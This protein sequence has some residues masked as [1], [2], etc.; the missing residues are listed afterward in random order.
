MLFKLKILAIGSLAF[1]LLPFATM[2]ADVN[3]SF[4]T[5]VVDKWVN[6]PS[7]E[8]VALIQIMTC[9][10]GRGG[11]NEK[12]FA[13][14]SW[15]GIVDEAKCGIQPDD[16]SG[17]VK[18][19]TVQF[20][21]SYAGSGTQEVV[22]FMEQSD[23]T[24]VVMNLQIKEGVASLPP[25]G[26]FYS[27]FY[28][29]SDEDKDF[30]NQTQLLPHGFGEVVQVGS[31][32]V[33]KSAISPMGDDEPATVSKVVYTNGSVSDLTYGF[34]LYG[35]D[36]ANEN[37][38]YIGKA[39]A[40]EVYSAFID[41]NNALD[42]SKNQCKFRDST[43]QSSWM[44]ALYDVNSGAR[45]KLT[46]PPFQFTV[47]ADGS[48][49]HAKKSNTWMDNNSLRLGMDKIESTFA[50]TRNDTS[51]PV[52]MQWT[53]T[54]METK[55]F[56]PFSPQ[57]DDIF[58]S[59]ESVDGRAKWDGR[60]LR[61]GMGNG[62]YSTPINVKTRVWSSFYNSEF[63]YDGTAIPGTW[64]MINMTPF[65]SSDYPIAGNSAHYKCFATYNCPHQTAASGNMNPTLG[66]YS[67]IIADGESW[68]GEF[69]GGSGLVH[70]GTTQFNYY[71][72]AITPPDGYM[73]ATLYW[74]SDG[75]ESLTSSDLPVKF[76]FNIAS[77][78]D[79]SNGWH[80]KAV[81]HENSSEVFFTANAQAPDNNNYLSSGQM[82]ATLIPSAS[83]CTDQN[84]DTCDDSVQFSTSQYVYDQVLIPKDANGTP[85]DIS[86]AM[87]MKF[88]QSNLTDLNGNGGVSIEYP[89]TFRENEWIEWLSSTCKPGNMGAL[90]LDIDG[91]NTT[92]E[93]LI[94]FADFNDKIVNIEYD[95]EI[96]DFPGYYDRARSSNISLINP[97]DGTLF[98]DMTNGNKYKYKA[99]GI[100]TL[101]V[102]KASAATC[103]AGVQLTDIPN[104]FYSND[105][106]SLGNTATNP[107]PTQKWNDKLTG[108][109][110]IFESGVKTECD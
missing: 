2:A 49:G 22:G 96:R 61:Q 91:D 78:Y 21:S 33:V 12:G 63:A 64:K 65:S 68:W 98:E 9:I 94:N 95:G 75:S 83:S 66:E 55:K 23:G 7:N 62:T 20:T 1:I 59:G 70:N 106:P 76:N 99:L 60:V 48:R 57:T 43:W 17:G 39:S 52:T 82:W 24:K 77:V 15:I 86:P 36:N 42:V 3:D 109:S 37:G 53:P 69:H 105:L 79:R 16:T 26:Q 97:I 108:L 25:Y 6:D 102:P 67:K 13:N 45:L 14:K 104:G 88:K 72:T 51:A 38:T 40:T 58:N 93:I 80:R 100:D 103:N 35:A 87:K 101:F 31:D 10:A 84:W 56:L 81:E 85:I 30:A 46:T 73:S 54:K 8:A 18:K 34:L 110:C 41:A 27:S 47:D 50:V 107:R 32:V 5:A 28:F 4:S 74:D 11:V 71:L 44:G 92:C 89:A 90:D 29:V 19:S